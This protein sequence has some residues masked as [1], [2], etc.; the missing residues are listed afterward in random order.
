MR[1]EYLLNTKDTDLLIPWVE[2]VSVEWENAVDVSFTYRDVVVQRSGVRTAQIRLAGSAGPLSVYMKGRKALADPWVM[3]GKVK[4]ALEEWGESSDRS[5]A[6]YSLAED[7]AFDVVPLGYS[8]RR[9]TNSRLSVDY[10]LR[11]RVLRGLEPR[12]LAAQ[13]QKLSKPGKPCNFDC[14]MKK[15]RSNADRIKKKIK[16]IK[17]H[18]EA[19]KQKIHQVEA[20]VDAYISIAQDVAD[21]VLDSVR[22]L[23]DLLH[24]PERLFRRMQTVWGTLHEAYLEAKQTTVGYYR[25]LMGEGRPDDAAEIRTLTQSLTEVQDASDEA[26]ALLRQTRGQPGVIRV[27]AIRPGEDIVGFAMRTTGD[28][29]AWK[30][31]VSLNGLIPPFVSDAGL[32]GTV[33]PGDILKAPGDVKASD[34]RPLDRAMLA[35]IYGRDLRLAKGDLVWQGDDLGVVT[36]VNNVVQ[37][38]SIRLSTPKGSNLLY[39]W[40]GLPARVGD[41]LDLA[42]YGRFSRE[43]AAQILSDDRVDKIEDLNIRDTGDGVRATAGVVLKDGTR[44]EATA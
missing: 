40:L 43:F 31:V 10:D 17:A 26:V 24:M 7:W 15:L 21:M 16:R 33:R 20:M 11:F 12:S 35:M 38:I 8:F 1:S 18:I 27:E 9:G 13:A 25:R 44:L 4:D 22:T 23:R 34:A 14:K 6:L 19:I 29:E 5:L 36:G 32:P 42:T 30:Q 28:P 3:L 2:D 37:S 39:P 41:G